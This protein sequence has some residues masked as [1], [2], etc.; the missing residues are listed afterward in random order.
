MKVGGGVVCGGPRG[1]AL[2]TLFL[3]NGRARLRCCASSATPGNANKNSLG[4]FEVLA[5]IVGI[6][7]MQTI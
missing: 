5:L 1:A 4:F 3:G 7:E 2:P 6:V